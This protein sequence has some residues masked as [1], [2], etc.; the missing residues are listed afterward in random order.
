M[1]LP[2]PVRLDAVSRSP[3]ER[4]MFEN[5][6]VWQE[7]EPLLGDDT[8]TTEWLLNCTPAMQRLAERSFGTVSTGN[9]GL[10]VL[11]LARARLRARGDPLLQVSP[12][13]HQQLSQ[14]DLGERLPV[15][16]FIPPFPL[17]YVEFARPSGFEVHNPLSGW[18]EVEGVYVGSYVLP[19]AHLLHTHTRRSR[20][21]GLDPARPTRVIELAVTGS[22]LGKRN[23]LDDFS[24]NMTLLVQDEEET[25]PAMLGRHLAC[26]AGGWL[27][28]RP[29]YRPPGAEEVEAWRRVLDHLAKVLLYLNLPDAQRTPVAERRALAA[30]LAQLGPKKAARLGRKLPYAYDRILIGPTTPA[31]A[32]GGPPDGDAPVQQLRP[33]WRRGHFR[34]IQHGAGRTESRLGWIR[35]VLVNASRVT[36]TAPTPKAYT[37]R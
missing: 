36:G 20:E 13:L 27:R 6:G 11:M 3:F 35:P 28:S 1:R 10:I 30:R 22:P 19:A 2:H 4:G 14:T 21:L 34:R 16:H 17:V 31:L 37:L 12:A 29:D 7:I 25:L 26:Y 24:Q 9:H 8:V 32:D 23:A 18:H 33:H 15:A 5:A